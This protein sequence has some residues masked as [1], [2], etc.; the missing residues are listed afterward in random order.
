MSPSR[1]KIKSFAKI[2]RIVRSAK[3]AGKVIV[4]TNGCFDVIH[5]GHI[6]T[7]EWAKNKGDILIVGIDSDVS[8]RANKGPRRPIIPA[9]ERAFVLASL[10]SV[11]YVFIFNGKS[12][13]P[14]IKKIKP[15]IHVKG[16]GSEKDPR[17]PS[18]A[19]V[20]KDRG[21]KVAFA[22]KIRGKSTTDIIGTILKRYKKITAKLKNITAF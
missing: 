22:P 9:K 8:V 17:F 21:G 5:T 6:A 20:I 13:I 14:W 11:D 19:K 10:S 16:E 7:L 2:E 15:M 12:P 3:R 1:R 18:E 4:T